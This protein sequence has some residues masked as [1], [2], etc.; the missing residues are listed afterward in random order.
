MT[1][2]LSVLLLFFN[3]MYSFGKRHIKVTAFSLL[4]F[5]WVLFW[6]ST[7]NPDYRAYSLI[8]QSNA[9][10]PT[11]SMEIGYILL[12][13]IGNLLGL[14]YQMFLLFISLFS[15]S[16]MHNTIR[17]YTDNLN[18]V[19]SL[20]FLF[21]FFLDVV[22]IRNF[23]MMAIFIF[24]TR[25]LLSNEKLKYCL[26][27]L[28]ASTIHITAFA[29]MPMV[30]INI[31]HKNILAR[32]LVILS[33]AI[34]VVILL[35]NKQIPFLNYLTIGT[36][37]DKLES[38]FETKTRYGFLIFWGLQI[39]SYAMMFITKKL[40]KKYDK[41]EICDQGRYIELVYWINIL[42]FVFFPL[43]L[44]NSNFTRLMR[45]N[46]LLNYVAFAITTSIIPKSKEKVI[47]V[48]FIFLYI[49]ILFWSMLSSDW[50]IIVKTILNNNLVF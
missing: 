48:L 22:Q 6:G 26:S 32:W 40:Y 41:K 5:A 39:L 50:E 8:Y 15:F 28:I 21:P 16:I 12:I 44:I 20:Y 42:S 9:E 27:I 37:I 10:I 11:E 45:N 47:Y 23:V 1:S 19:Y 33:L 43:Y 38:Y 13:K 31:K 25:Y 18:F 36:G 24:S 3:L 17:K 4:L 14:N 29:Y 35:N 30:F 34:S 46:I 7:I 2:I 49:S